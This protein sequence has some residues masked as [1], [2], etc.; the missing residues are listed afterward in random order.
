MCVDWKALIPTI[1]NPFLKYTAAA[2]G[3]PLAAL[4]SRL[5]SCISNCQE[6]KLTTILCLFFDRFASIDVHSCCCFT[7]PQTLVLHGLFPTTLA[8]PRMAISIELLSFYR[9]LF[10]R[11][12]DAVNALAAT[13]STY[14]S[15]RGFRVTNHKGKT[16]RDPFRHGLSQAAQ[17]F[18]ILEPAIGS[19]TDSSSSTPSTVWR[20]ESL[21]RSSCTEIL[22]QHC[23]AC[24]GSISF[25]RPLDDGGD[26]HVATDSNFHHRH[27]RSAGNCPSFYEPS[28]FIPK[29]QVDTVGRHIDHARHHPSKS[30][31]SG[32]PDEAI[33]QCEASYEATDGQKQKAAMDNFDDTGLMML[34]CRHDIPLFF[35]NI[36]TPG[37]Q[38]KFSIALIHHLFS[39][40]PSQANV[41]VLYDVG[42]ILARSLSHFNILGED[43]VSCL[44]FATTA[45]HAYGHEWACQLVYN[46]RITSGLGLSDGEGT[47]RLWSRFIKL[48]GIEW[49]SS[50]QR[51]IWL[52][53]H[54]AATIG[55]EMWR[56]L[57]D[58]LRRCLQ[59]GV[60]EQGSVAHEVL[61]NCGVSIMELWEQWANQRATQL[62]IRLHAPSRV[63]K[64]LDN[65]LALQGDL[66]SSSKVLQL[67]QVTIEKGNVSSSVLDVLASLERGHARLMTKTEALYSS[68]NVH[69]RI[70]E[71]KDRA[72]GSFFEW[73]KLDCAVGGKDKPLGMKLHQQTW[74][75][76]AK[77]QPAL[78]AAIRKYN[79]YCEQLSQ[80]HNLTWAIPLPAA[81]PTTL[82]NLRNDPTLMQDV[83]I[84]PSVGEVPRWLEDID[85]CDGIH[86]LLKHKHCLEEQHH[87]GIEADN[88]C[89]WFGNELTA[90][91]VALRQ[92]ENCNY[93][94]ILRQHLEATLELLE[95]WPTALCSHSCY[96]NRA[97]VA[98]QVTDTIAGASQPSL[99]WLAPVVI[100]NH[101]N[102]PDEDMC[103]LTDLLGTDSTETPVE[104]EQVALLDIDN[105]DDL[106]PDLEAETSSRVTLSWELPDVITVDCGVDMA[107]D[108]HVPAIMPTIIRASVDGARLNDTCIN[109]CATLLYSAFMPAAARCA[110]LSTHDLPR[111]CFHANDDLL[112]RNVSWTHFWEKPVWIIPIHHSLPVGHWVLCTVDFPSRKL[113]LFDSLAEQKPWKNE[114]KDIMWLVCHLSSIATRKMGTGTSRQDR[115]DWMARPILLEPRQTNGHDCGVWVLA[116]MAAILRGYD[117][118]D[119]KENNITHFRHF[120]RVLIHR[121]VE[122]A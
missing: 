18:N 17:W 103:G 71:L 63:K 19:F 15:R 3:Q 84:T 7:L 11:S 90:I 99:R 14:Y 76:I 116:Q 40:L 64:E 49:V 41:V 119:V 106:E 118:T 87:L 112:W 81:L 68:L 21:S 122:L 33:D 47:E 91:Q 86:T 107:K 75:A 10:E 120:L 5:S 50:C 58:W 45:M 108:I 97:E 54:H 44:R 20:Q 43:I 28:Y 94:F 89:R 114:I 35:A 60:G 38:Q 105:Q 93:H 102:S 16:V 56:E 80:L 46:P 13:L 36:D 85:V 61:D 62:S 23:P 29:A 100:D 12:C 4:G 48:I 113:L 26:I 65:V 52:L 70:P 83:W 104:S 9:A 101:F 111:V 115:G 110:V 79:N 66:D 59:K 95:R 32:V 30:S 37:E 53:D 39:L 55:Y 121:V 88:M 8:Q 117:I 6:Q 74:K 78:M 82:V 57:G 42:C 98:V 27:R 92:P 25:G 24:F 73:D 1:I 77:C 67:A 72:V 31:Q 22:V 34:I 109:G 2:L 96:I 69:D 51:R